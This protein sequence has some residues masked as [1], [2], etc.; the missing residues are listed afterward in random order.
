MN[1]EKYIGESAL[2]DKPG[3]KINFM[4]R[5]G[6]ITTTKLADGSVYGDK[7]LPASISS[8][9]LAPD[10]ILENNLSAEI[11]K[12]INNRFEVFGDLYNNP[13]EEDLSSER[14]D[15]KDVMKF[16]DRAYI[17]Q[18]FSGKGYKI[19]RKNITPVSLAVTKIV[20]SSVP[21]SDGYLAFII[22][23][24]E[25]HVDVV[26]STDTTTDKV[27]SKIAL[28]LTEAM[29]E[30][31]V[32][33][34]SSTITLTRKFGGNVSTP[35]SFSAVGTGASC[36]ITD[37][38]KIELRNI[39]TPVMMNQP[40]TIY[41]IRYDFDLN[42]ET[43]EMKEG[44]TLKFEG[45]VIR[46]GVLKGK[47][48]NNT[49]KPEWFGAKGD[50][51]H[52]D[53]EAINIC[54]GL[55]SHGEILFEGE[56]YLTQGNHV[57][58]KSLTIKGKNS[59]KS[60]TIIKHIGTDFIF[61]AQAENLFVPCLF[62]N[63]FFE[64]DKSNTTA[65]IIVSDAW[66]HSIRNCFF[67]NIAKTN[68]SAIKVYNYKKWT[69]NV[70][71][72]DCQIRG[73]KYGIMFC[74]S[75][76]ESATN[77]FFRSKLNNISISKTVG[78]DALIILDNAYCYGSDWRDLTYWDEAGG[79]H[80]GIVLVNNSFLGGE[81]ELW[82][83]GYGGQETY[84]DLIMVNVKDGCML[85]VKGICT[86][87]QDKG[88]RNSNKNA[89]K[90]LKIIHQQTSWRSENNL[91]LARFSGAYVLAGDTSTA[92]AGDI[93][94]SSLFLPPFSEYDIELRYSR[95][96]RKISVITGDAHTLP[97][98]TEQGITHD[99]INIYPYNK[100]NQGS[101]VQDKGLAF[102]LYAD[103]DITDLKW[104]LKITQK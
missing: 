79:G 100:G 78:N 32:N 58:T 55:L 47:I 96:L 75:N 82:S 49:L 89:N 59:F 46:N 37:S 76:N 68:S 90:F 103:K 3:K 20:V 33:L 51:V 42:G 41:E 11:R 74:K 9:K 71:I 52:D 2:N 67:A 34:N 77:S 26:A 29:A 21:T 101:W 22:N 62:E 38:T 72:C 30:Y 99:D 95:F 70:I 43:I 19:L 81:V 28:K 56:T 1:K 88:Y 35:A 64:G 63:L 23:G 93:L 7:I 39:V 53:T 14:I 36:I 45:G 57:I 73:S 24:V 97:I 27:A 15:G 94:Y 54:I 50:G 16:A 91:P 31:E 66:G 17:P 98:I 8:D 60:N 86:Y 85:N 25:S 12:K 6:S 102:Y 40:N 18:E 13:D 84:T 83:D 87:S 104:N 5:D 44:C 61:W 65:A 69:E 80:N 4:I 48:V 92:K 10:G